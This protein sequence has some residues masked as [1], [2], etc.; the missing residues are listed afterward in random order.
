ML[1][2]GVASK[3]ERDLVKQNKREGERERERIKVS[4]KCFMGSSRENIRV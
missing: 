3:K 2:E 1:K 4:P